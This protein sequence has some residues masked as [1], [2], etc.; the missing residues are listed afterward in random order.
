MSPRFRQ[1]ALRKHPL[2]AQVGHFTYLDRMGQQWGNNGIFGM[3]PTIF[4]WRQ[5]S[6]YFVLVEIRVHN[7]PGLAARNGAYPVL[8]GAAEFYRN[9]PNLKK[10]ADGT[11]PYQPQRIR[12]S[13]F[14][15]PGT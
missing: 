9:F 5:R 1:T 6:R 13:T 7:G 3:C 14:G 12:T 10:E 15:A 11:V 8:R 2:S 4:G